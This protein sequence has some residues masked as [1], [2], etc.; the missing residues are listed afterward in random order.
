M[1]QSDLTIWDVIDKNAKL[2]PSKNSIIYM[3]LRWSFDRFANEVHSLAGGLSSLGM[4]KG[5]RIA[6]LAYNCHEYLR[7]Y[8][9]AARIGAIVIPINWRL[10]QEEIQFI[11]ED[12]SPRLLVASQ[13]FIETLKNQVDSCKS[14]KHRLVIGHGVSSFIPIEEVASAYSSPGSVELDQQDPLIL[15]YTAAVGGH[16]KGATIT[17]G[18][19]IAA[20]LQGIATFG[21]KSD[22]VHL[23]MLPLYHIGGLVMS[24]SVMHAGGRNVMIKRFGPKEAAELIDK[25]K[26]TIM[27]TFPP[28]LRSIMDEA[29]ASGSSLSSLRIGTGIEQTDTIQ[30]FQQATG[31]KFWSGFGQTETMGFCTLAPFDECPGSAGSQGLLVRVRIVDDYDMDVPTGQTGEIVLKGPIV[32]KGYWGME[33]ETAYTFRGGWHHTGDM[34]RLDERGYLWYLRPKAEKELM[35]PGG[36]NVYPLEVEKVLLE[37]P[38]VTEACVFGIPDEQWGEAIKAVCVHTAGSSLKTEELIEFVANRIARYKKPKFLTFVDTLPKRE[39][40]KIDREKV[41][42]EHRKT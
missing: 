34:G 35:K 2:Y 12:G 17:H 21:I 33:K 22:D 36:E 29:N 26:V 42:T 23:N 28:M 16:P 25:E 11:F 19:L 9:A 4:R 6:V 8:G 1:G 3:D 5:D 15:M 37:H 18:N 38:E 32:F 31:A 24:L 40:S 41:K 20:N 30:R 10:K 13:E 7:I 27:Q 14:I 39:N